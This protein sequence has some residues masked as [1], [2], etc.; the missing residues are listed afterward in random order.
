MFAVVFFSGFK[1]MPASKIAFLKMG[2]AFNKNN[3]S[4]S[5]FFGRPI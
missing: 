3:E 2:I 1:N 5:N 4:S